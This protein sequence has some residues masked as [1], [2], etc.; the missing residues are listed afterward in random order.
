MTV[1][2]PSGPKRQTKLDFYSDAADH[3][4]FMKDIWRNNVSHARRPYHAGE[5]K[6]VLDRV[7]D[8]MRFLAISLS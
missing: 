4:M 6:V 7:R 3:G 1:L 8:F 2:L 5:A